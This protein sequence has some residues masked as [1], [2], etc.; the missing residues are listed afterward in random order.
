MRESTVEL[1][2]DLLKTA[3]GRTIIDNSGTDGLSNTLTCTNER[4]QYDIRFADDYGKPLLESNLAM[5]RECMVLLSSP[6]PPPSPLGRT[7]GTSSSTPQQGEGGMLMLG[8]RS[9]LR[10][11]S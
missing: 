9:G 2:L 6:P 4:L 11:E 8:P 10:A 3:E 7:P 1:L 5:V